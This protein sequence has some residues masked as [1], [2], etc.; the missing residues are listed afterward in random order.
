MKWCWGLTLTPHSSFTLSSARS[1]EPQCGQN[2]ADHQLRQYKMWE[3]QCTYIV[4]ILLGSK[5]VLGEFVLTLLYD[6]RDLWVWMV[7]C[8]ATLH[9]SVICCILVIWGHFS[10][11]FYTVRASTSGDFIELWDCQTEPH[12]S[13]V[14]MSVQ[15][16]GSCHDVQSRKGNLNQSDRQGEASVNLC[17]LSAC[18]RLYVTVDEGAQWMR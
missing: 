2:F 9:A 8:N 10:P 11:Y 4:C 12:K 16:A 13:A 15:F 6:K 14:T 7:P 18:S 1:V 17:L 5:L 3:C